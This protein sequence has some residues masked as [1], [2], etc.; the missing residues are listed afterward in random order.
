MKHSLLKPGFVRDVLE[1]GVY[2]DGSGL[3]LAVNVSVGGK[4]I[5]KG[6]FLQDKPNDFLIHKSWFY[7]YKLNG[8]EH[9]FGL[10]S[11]ADV[12][13]VAARG[14]V[15]KLRAQR[16]LGI[17]DNPVAERRAKRVSAQETAIRSKSESVSFDRCADE[18][19]DSMKASWH[20]PEQARK[21]WLASL[22]YASAIFGQMPIAKLDTPLAMQCLRPLW[23]DKTETARRLQNRLERIWDFGKVMGYCNG[24]ENP[25]RWRGHLDKLLPSV[26][27]VKEAGHHPSM[28]Y[29]AIPAFIPKL[30]A[31]SS[32][33]ARALEFY[34][35]A[36]VRPSEVLGMRWEEVD[37]KARIWTV[38]L[39]RKGRKGKKNQRKDFDS[40]LCDAAVA[41]LEKLKAT[42]TSELVFPGKGNKPLGESAMKDTLFRL[43]GAK[44]PIID[45]KR[46]SNY[47]MSDGSEAPVPNGY[48][49]SFRNWAGDMT[50]M[51]E[52]VVKASMSHV[53][54]NKVEQAY[55]RDGSYFP[56]RVKLMKLW[57][58]FVTSAK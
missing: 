58:R 6:R 55:M 16:A 5:S 39:D 26:S 1:P 49:S 20:D 8:V 10:G 56:R 48:R 2:P 35:Y 24:G 40:P 31:D 37:F 25:C 14:A 4:I 11:V 44:R 18:F 47:V 22:R 17:N 30:K 15:K 43:V 45:G 57:G 29:A 3:Y 34:I 46:V 38:P 13:L 52:E 33:A 9:R 19:L 28:P 51:A 32:M 54:G 36:I 27:V 41:L 53:V 42:S 50:M 7:R 23:N 12:S 21:D